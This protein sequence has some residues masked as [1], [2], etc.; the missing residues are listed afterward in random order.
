MTTPNPTPIP[1]RVIAY[2]DGF[3]L[4]F[5]LK[6]KGWKQ[7]Y[8]LDIRAA[9]QALLLPQQ[10]L[11]SVKYF[12]SRVSAAHG[13]PAQARRQATYLEALATLPGTSLY[14]GHYLSKA[15]QCHACGSQ[16]QKH[17]EKMTDVNIAT[18]LLVDAFQ[19]RFDTAMLVTADSDLAGPITRLRELFPAKRV[20]VVFPPDR[21]SKRLDQLASATLHLGRGVLARSQLPDHV[22]KPDGFALQRPANWR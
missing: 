20:V 3:N 11:A 21:A 14:F 5:G 7:F 15:V 2:L 17:D 9:V 13:D 19:D 22:I 1:Q 16:W 4:F 10:Q 18:E 6:S 12:T 8:W